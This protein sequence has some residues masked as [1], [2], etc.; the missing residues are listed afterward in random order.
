M[1][2]ERPNIGQGP[3]GKLTDGGVAPD[4]SQMTEGVGGVRDVEP[5]ERATVS[6]VDGDNVDPD[7]ERSPA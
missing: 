4:A 7:S 1:D 5:D 2:D 6:D 3:D